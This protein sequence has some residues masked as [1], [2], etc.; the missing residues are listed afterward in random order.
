MR[1][2]ERKMGRKSA[3]YWLRV[4]LTKDPA[5]W[6]NRKEKRNEER[7][8]KKHKKYLSSLAVRFN[9]FI[10]C[11]VS[12]GA[13][14]GNERRIGLCV[15]RMWKNVSGT[16]YGEVAQFVCQLFQKYFEGWI[17]HTETGILHVA[18]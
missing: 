7:E 9:L 16:V 3:I 8:R 12:V 15:D 11:S 2:I 10:S 4:C 6:S 13:A 17:R 5:E 18:R 14:N 1:G